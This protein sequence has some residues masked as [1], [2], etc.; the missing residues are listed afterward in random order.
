MVFLLPF[1]VIGL[2]IFA[3]DFIYF[4]DAKPINTNT[5]EIRMEDKNMS[6]TYLDKYIK[7]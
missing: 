1:I 5:K 4:K 6:N 3:I 7:K 2:I